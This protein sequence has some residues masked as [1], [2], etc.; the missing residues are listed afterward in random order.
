MQRRK[1]SLTPR[2]VPFW[3]FQWHGTM[4]ATER[5][6]F[7]QNSHFQKVNGYRWLIRIIYEITLHA[8]QRQSVKTL[9]MGIEY[10]LPKA[11]T[12]HA[13]G[14]GGGTS[15]RLEEKVNT[16]QGA[17]TQD[18]FKIWSCM[19]ANLKTYSKLF[20]IGIRPCGCKKTRG[21]KSHGTV[22]L[23]DCS[24]PFRRV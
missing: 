13:W 4:A 12:S 24:L 17:T 10:T 5:S 15:S 9:F 20:R 16:A 19:L 6:D 2:L 18:Q 23:S 22:A 14:G 7:L 3:E 8:F 11:S 1:T 21:E